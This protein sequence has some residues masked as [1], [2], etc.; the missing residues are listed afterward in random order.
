MRTVTTV[1]AAALLL[2]S[3]CGYVAFSKY[4]GM[5]SGGYSGGGYS[6]DTDDDETVSG[7]N[8]GDG[9]EDGKFNRTVALDPHDQDVLFGR[10]KSTDSSIRKRFDDERYSES[11]TYNGNFESGSGETGEPS[12]VDI[13]PN[14]DWGDWLMLGWNYDTKYRIKWVG[15]MIQI[16]LKNDSATF[17]YDVEVVLKAYNYYLPESYRQQKS[18]PIKDRLGPGVSRIAVWNTPLYRG[19]KIQGCSTVSD[20]ATRVK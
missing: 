11:S 12:D 13:P 14:R 20:K 7:L 18:P 8:M 1:C 16:E 19:N 6:G 10:S 3:G 2:T 9:S 4:E 5:K 17:T 15:D